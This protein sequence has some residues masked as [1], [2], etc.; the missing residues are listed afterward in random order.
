MH[1]II[2]TK[3]QDFGYSFMSSESGPR[4]F[5]FFNGY[6]AM[7]MNDNGQ[8]I[9]T[10]EYTKDPAS[11]I[12]E[13]GEKVLSLEFKEKMKYPSSWFWQNGSYTYMW[14]GGK[15]LAINNNAVV[16]GY[17]EKGAVIWDKG[18]TDYLFDLIE[19]SE[20]WESLDDATD[21]NNRG[22]IV[23]SGIYM[24]RRTAF[25]LTPCQG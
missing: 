11:W 10:T 14:N 4:H 25:L 9:L 20:G 17:D 15:A 8:V 1:M 3:F 21:I 7:D 18:E 5:V 12:W 6:A 2:S 19:N 16:V 23:G 22:E 13:H 24:G